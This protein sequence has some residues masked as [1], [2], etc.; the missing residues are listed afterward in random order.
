MKKNHMIA[1]FAILAAAGSVFA[2]DTNRDEYFSNSGFTSTM[3]RVQVRGEL[4]QARTQGLMNQ[5]EE[6]TFGAPNIGARGSAGARPSV[7]GKTR[8]Q[9]RTELEE[10]RSQGLFNQKEWVGQ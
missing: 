1:T 3:T 4:E 8:A 2:D 10:A 9:V 6:V 7:S 5:G